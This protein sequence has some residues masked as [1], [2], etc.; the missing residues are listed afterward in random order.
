MSFRSLCAAAAGLAA[1]AFAGAA[2]SAAPA[3]KVTGQVSATDGRWDYVSFDPAMR[4]LYLVH[5]DGVL[6]LD[7][8]SGKLT[9]KL[10]EAPH[11]HQVLPLD[12]G[13]VLLVTVGGTN[14]ARFIDAATGKTLGE[15]ATGKGPDAAVYDPATG[16]VAVAD[17]GGG[18]LVL[19]DPKSMK[20]V[21]SIQVGGALEYL[22]PDGR[23]RLFMVIE[24]K[25]EAVVIDE[26][27]HTVAKRIT[28]DGCDEP[29]GL[30]YAAQ[31][32]VMIAACSN[33]KAAL[34]DAAQAKLVGLLDIGQHPD[35]VI[36]DPERRLAFVP[37]G[38]SGELDVIDAS[39]PGHVHVV[40]K[41]ATEK[42][43]RTGAVDPKTGKVY[44]PAARYAPPAQA[45]QRPAMQP[46]SFHLVVVSPGA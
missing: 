26:K 12:G 1:L 44:L 19:I 22:A 15:V 16:L 7:V 32:G 30:A 21:A 5:A 11:G 42:S 3:Y 8:D 45:G 13:K 24:D 23:G 2:A 20:S 40:Q 9:P 25:N 18:D 35:A 38:G 41:V 34:I 33:G 46:G 4:R 43:A 14:G 36:Y 37:C 6:A 28:L 27:T 39:V 17:H 29:S 10:A 31:A